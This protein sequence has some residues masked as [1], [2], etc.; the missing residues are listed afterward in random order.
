MD[1]LM[2]PTF[3]WKND[4]VCLMIY[5]CMCACERQGSKEAEGAE[6]DGHVTVSGAAALHVGNYRTSSTSSTWPMRLRALR[7]RTIA[8][9]IMCFRSSSI[10]LCVEAISCVESAIC[11]LK[12][13]SLTDLLVNR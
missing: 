7:I 13:L 6:E 8:A 3:G 11:V 9:S 2:T 1:R 5:T 10:N 12:T 4:L